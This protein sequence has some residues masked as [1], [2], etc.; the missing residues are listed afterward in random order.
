[1]VLKVQI[2]PFNSTN[3][4]SIQYFTFLAFFYLKGSIQFDNWTESRWETDIY[5]PQWKFQNN[6]FTIFGWS[7]VS[8]NTIQE[9]ILSISGSGKGERKFEFLLVFLTTDYKQSLKK[10]RNSESIKSVVRISCKFS[11]SFSP[12]PPLESKK[13]SFSIVF[14]DTKF[15]AKIIKLMFLIFYWGHDVSVSLLGYVKNQE[16]S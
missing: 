12:F 1:M 13:I 3:L 7:L 5:C 11:T 14:R 16:T 10:P 9:E 15:H 6:S 4:I 8:V 2:W